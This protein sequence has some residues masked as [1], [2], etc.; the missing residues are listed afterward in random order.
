[1]ADNTD[2]N[3]Q[4]PAAAAVD[5]DKPVTETTNALSS[6][7]VTDEPS[8]PVQPPHLAPVPVQQ[9]P[10]NLPGNLANLAAL[11]DADAAEALDNEFLSLLPPCILPRIDKLKSLNK[12]RD[13]I[14]DE[15]RVERAKLEMKFSKRMEPLYEERRGVVSGDFDGVIDSEHEKKKDEKDDEESVEE[16]VVQDVI[17]DEVNG[18]QQGE[19]VKGIPQFWACAMGHV[20]VIAELISEADVDCLDHLTDVTC[21]DF[22]DGLG[23]EL[24]FHFAPNPFFTN[25]VLTKRYEVPN[26]LT[27]DEPILKNVT[28]TPI[29][30]KKGQSLTYKEVTKKQRKKGGPNAGQ[31]RSVTKKERSESLFHFF[32]PPKMPGLHDVIDEDEADAVEEAFDHDYDVAQAFRGH[33]IPKAVLWFTGEAMMEDYDE[34]MMEEMMMEQQAAGGEGGQPQFN[35]NGGDGPF[36]PPAAG[37]GSDPECKNS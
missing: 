33:L 14:L 28:G 5:D 16:G 29:D 20:D 19:V 34:E 36:P 35:F 24:T 7:S 1:M 30:W 6:I 21:A 15:Y 17:E 10:L 22:P 32:T 9:L 37:D 26:L 31:V 11:P 18:Q 2:N 13:E 12:A 3:S 27:E 8:S 23:F 25:T 4:D